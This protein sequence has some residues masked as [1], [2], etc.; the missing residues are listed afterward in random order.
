[1][2]QAIEEIRHFRKCL[3]FPQ[4]PRQFQKKEYNI[5]FHNVQNLGKGKTL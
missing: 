2:S 3:G 5:Y 1:M 4:L